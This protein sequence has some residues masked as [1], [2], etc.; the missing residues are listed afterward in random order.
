MNV[1]NL[2]LG[3]IKELSKY[4]PKQGTEAPSQGFEVGK[5][6]FVRT[7][8]FHY[9]GEVVEIHSRCVIMKNVTW[10]ADDGRFNKAMKGEWDSQAEHEPYPGATRVG[11]FYSA[12]V[13]AAEWQHDLITVVK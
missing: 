13:D 3:Q 12:M 1:D 6:Y 10:V 5:R 7:V 11:L 2:T 8:T 4:L 9:L